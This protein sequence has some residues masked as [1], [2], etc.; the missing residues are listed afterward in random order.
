MTAAPG[1]R[2][3]AVNPISYWSKAGKIKEVFEEA[4]ADFA[5]IGYSVV[6]SPAGE[7]ATS[8]LSSKRYPRITTA[9]S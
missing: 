1:K 7:S 6:K 9:T 8:T 2:R 4:F 3:I 5:K